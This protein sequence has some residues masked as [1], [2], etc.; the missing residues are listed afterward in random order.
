MLVSAQRESPAASY[1]SGRRLWA[2]GNTAV[3]DEV[4]CLPLWETMQ[5]YPQFKSDVQNSVMGL[6]LL[7]PEATT[8]VGVV[9]GKTQLQ[10]FSPFIPRAA[11][12]GGKEPVCQSRRHKRCGFKPWVRKI[13]WKRKWQLTPV[14]LP[15]ESHGQRSPVGLHTVHKGRRVRHD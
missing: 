14:F 12:A 5:F 2:Q 3:D 6:W 7:F 10:I 15:G 11:G 9:G 4:T 13:P 8:A 1:V